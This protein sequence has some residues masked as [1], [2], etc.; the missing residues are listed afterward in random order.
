M[1]RYLNDA[2][3][4]LS[5]WVQ[6]RCKVLAKD[7]FDDGQVEEELQ[8]AMAALEERPVLLDCCVKEIVAARK[9]YVVKSF[10]SALTGEEE[11]EEEKETGESPLASR[12][13][14]SFRKPIEMQALDPLRYV[15]DML[16]WIHRSAADRKSVV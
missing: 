10:F 8:Q 12:N 15:G 3:T 5:Q 2:Y 6:D 16:A 11:E 14:L 13:S 7:G 4:R 1:A 9:S